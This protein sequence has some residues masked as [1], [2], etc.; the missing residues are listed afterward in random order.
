MEKEDRS[1]NV[2]YDP[3]NHQ[4]M[5]DLRA[6]KVAAVANSIP[7][8]N[9]YGDADADTL[10]V[11]WGGT[12]GTLLTA[13]ENLNGLG[14][15]VAGAHFRYINPFPANT[16]DLLARYKKIIVCELNTGQLEVLLRA[17]FGVATIPLHKVQ[18]K[19]FLVSELIDFIKYHC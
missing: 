11:G 4:K 14:H 5:T 2:C 15:A 13:V 6:A 17:R 1:G 8:M 16:A 7:D 12:Y 19:P 3:A 18:G 10:V 9:V